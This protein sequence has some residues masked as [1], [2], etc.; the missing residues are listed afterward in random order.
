MMDSFDHPHSITHR[1]VP[2]HLLCPEPH[3]SRGHRRITRTTAPAT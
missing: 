1:V 2:A 3:Q